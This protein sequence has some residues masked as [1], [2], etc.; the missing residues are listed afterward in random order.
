M[1][2]H[3]TGIKKTDYKFNSFV[4][5]TLNMNIKE[6]YNMILTSGSGVSVSQ[7]ENSVII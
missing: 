6:I 4:G 1:A 5:N 3:Y 7:T 2:H